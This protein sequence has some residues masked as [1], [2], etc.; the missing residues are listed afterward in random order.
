[1]IPFHVTFAMPEWI[2]EGIRTNLYEVVGGVVR[3][4]EGKQVVMWLR[5]ALDEAAKAGVGLAP[6]GLLPAGAALSLAATASVAVIAVAGFA[7]LAH[8]QT[9]T[10]QRLDR[11]MDEIGLLR[12]GI[13][14]VIA[15]QVDEVQHKMETAIE[16]LRIEEERGGFDAFQPPLTALRECGKFYVAQIERLLRHECPLAVS[17]V[18]LE[19]ARLHLLASQA[20][21]RGSVLYLSDWGEAEAEAARDQQAFAACREALLAPLRDPAGHLAAFVR[22]S[23]QEDARMRQALPALHRPESYLL[24]RIEGLTR[25][26]ALL[27]ALNAVATPRA[28][29]PV[30]GIIPASMAPADWLPENV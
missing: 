27:R 17:P 8:R 6:L 16:I 29:E 12:L 11:M 26:P 19:L 13:D 24:P 15:N 23:E 22:L 14:T 18:F 5:P 3:L 10:E 28:G 9:Q 30:A 4:M 1:M 25:D 20:K 2:A 7:Y 21:A